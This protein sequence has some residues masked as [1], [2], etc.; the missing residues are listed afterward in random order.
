[1]TARWARLLGLAMLGLA[2]VALWG[3]ASA[4]PAP[5]VVVQP[6]PPLDQALARPCSLPPAPADLADFDAVDDWLL[7]QLLPAFADCARRQAALVEAWG[8]R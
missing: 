8:A 4:P 7:H 3:C 1:M 6:R 2:I 5:Q